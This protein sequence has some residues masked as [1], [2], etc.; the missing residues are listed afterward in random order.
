MKAVVLAA[1][2]VIAA[3]SPGAWAAAPSDT[4]QPVVLI[5]VRGHDEDVTAFRL[6]LDELLARIELDPRITAGAPEG[7]DP[8]DRPFATVLV[9]VTARNS[10]SVAVQEGRSGQV[11]L[12][13]QI[14]HVGSRALLIDT[15]AH[16]I[17]AMLETMVR[18]RRGRAEPPRAATAEDP[19]TDR[20]AQLP[21][22]VRTV[23]APPS[24]VAG[25]RWGFELSPFYAVRSFAVPD[26]RLMMNAGLAASAGSRAGRLQPSLSLSATYGLDVD[27][28]SGTG[29]PGQ[30]FG[31]MQVISLH[32]IPVINVIG[33][34][35]LLLQA[36][37]GGG[38]DIVR[39][40]TTA[41]PIMGPPGPMGPAN[42]P[43]P[44]TQ[45]R[46][47]DPLIGAQL[48][49][50]LALTAGTQLFVAASTDYGPSDPLQMGFGSTAPVP[51]SHWRLQGSLGLSVTLGG[52]PPG[53]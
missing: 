32:A 11:R 52:R 47:F 45:R 7:K 13:R 2:V 12:L 8:Q 41:P 23:A 16:V 53:G 46:R 30:G 38:L 17:Y 9:D 27:L 31:R 49:G 39:M 48:T 6:V 10:A 21:V 26:Q 20:A 34:G 29:M 35:R 36:G 24:G 43:A 4:A 40:E 44:P 51:M 3:R 14:E 15:V 33:R 37:I 18:E 28:G 5:A 42:G 25:A 50:R 19:A 22:L 1:A